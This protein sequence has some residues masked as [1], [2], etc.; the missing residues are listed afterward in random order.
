ML[1]PPFGHDLL[2]IARRTLLDDLIP[3][4]PP[5][6][7]YEARMV[8]NAMAIAGREIARADYSDSEADERI[9]AFYRE[10]GIGPALSAA[11][12]S[13]AE[14]IRTRRI[15]NAHAQRLYALLVSLT[16]AKLALSNPKYLHQEGG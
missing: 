9:A 7:V 12:S 8:A 16:R 4:L 5:D 3:L 1:N 13:L 14:L 15:D 2:A 6:K 11:E 10:A